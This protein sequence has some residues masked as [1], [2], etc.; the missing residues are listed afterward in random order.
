M[1]FASVN[2]GRCAVTALH[3][4]TCDAFAALEIPS[5][6][7]LHNALGQAFRLAGLKPFQSSDQA[8][9][10]TKQPPGS[11]CTVSI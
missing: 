10:P 11:K 5:T 6:A 3:W 1:A 4:L 2:D 9:V 7:K 8:A